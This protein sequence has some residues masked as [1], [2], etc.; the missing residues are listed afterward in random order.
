MPLVVLVVIATAA[1]TAVY[2]AV[3]L[4][5]ELDLQP[6]TVLDREGREI[7]TIEPEAGRQAVPLETVPEPV[8]DAV[9]AAEDAN[10]YDHGGV[11]I[12]G[13]ARAMIVNAVSGEIT[14]GGSTISQQYVKVLTADTDRTFTRKIREAALA[15][16][17]ERRLDKDEIL[18]R[19]LNNAYFGRGAY[20]IEAAAR[21]YFDKSAAQLEPAEGALLAGL[22]P[23]P[24][25]LDPDVNPQRAQQRYD[26]T[27]GRLEAHGW[28]A[29]SYPSRPPATVEPRSLEVGEAPYFLDAVRTELAERL[30]GEKA[31][32]TGGPTV[33]STLDLDMQEAAEAAEREVLREV[34]EARGAIVALDPEG[35][36]VRAMVG[37]RNHT[38]EPLNLAT[39]AVRQPGSTFKPMALAAWM[40]AGH[41]PDTTMPAPAEWRRP[42]CVGSDDAC[43][44]QNFGG[45]GYGSMTVREA[46]WRSVNTVYAQMGARLGTPRVVDMAEDAGVPDERLDPGVEAVLGAQELTPL[47]LAQ[48]YNTFASSGTHHPPRTVERVERDGEVVWQANDDGDRA[49]SEAVALNVTDVLRGVV[50]NGTG[51]AADIGRPQAGKTGTTSR[52]AD[53]WFAGYTPDLTAVV[54][55]GRPEGNEP[56]PGSPTGGSFPARAWAQFA[57]AAL[58]SVPASDFDEPPEIG[59]AESLEE[60]TPSPSP[61]ETVEPPP[62]P[63]DE[64]ADDERDDDSEPVPERRPERR[65][66]PPDDDGGGSDGSGSDGSGSDGS[67]GSDGSDDS[68]GVLPLPG[69]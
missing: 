5:P 61:E 53:A 30:G 9:V 49:M 67:G 44:V 43:T 25:R 46:T 26:Y 42:D 34:D 58:E 31:I 52:H 8:R 35:G 33:V 50:T 10:F 17:L 3:S 6:A 11:S 23:A 2:A 27:V 69:G 28:A 41:S 62:T 64:P 48:A 51:T 7:G 14:Q 18:E 65:E 68:D 1:M 45:A 15:V 54:W 39:R 32:F 38:D 24:S 55:L 22:L 20:G 12:P 16:K 36:Q 37:G 40:D 47:D 56:I 21:A 4:P 60:A 19:Y 13:V 66:P 57:S 29:G 59:D 63:V